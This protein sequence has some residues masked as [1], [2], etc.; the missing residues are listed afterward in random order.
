[1]ADVGVAGID[2][3]E[4]GQVVTAFVVPAARRP[5]Q[6][7]TTSATRSRRELAAFHAPRRLV[8][9]DEIPRTALGK[10]RRGDLAARA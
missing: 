5:R 3:P 10:L 1:V 7:S 2:D 6:R 9:V 8:V 4:W